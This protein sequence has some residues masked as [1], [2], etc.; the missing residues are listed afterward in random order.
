MIGHQEN[1]LL[2]HYIY[3]KE[4]EGKDDEREKDKK[5]R[6]KR[7]EENKKLFEKSKEIKISK[8]IQPDDILRI[9]YIDREESEVYAHNIIDHLSPKIMH[10]KKFDDSKNCKIFK[11]EN[12]EINNNNFKIDDNTQSRYIDLTDG[13]VNEEIESTDITDA[14]RTDIVSTDITVYGEIFLKNQW[15]IDPQIGSKLF[16]KGNPVSKKPYLDLLV[17]RELALQG[18]KDGKVNFFL[19]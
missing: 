8:R 10:G 7:N 19:I 17:A 4:K 1:R 16:K 18:K 13:D 14:A 9:Q 12:N 6:K 2:C 15:N 3:E 11:N 5:I